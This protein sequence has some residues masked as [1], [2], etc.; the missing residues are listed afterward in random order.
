MA[1]CCA[2]SPNESEIVEST[3]VVP[4][5]GNMTSRP[6][7]TEDIGLTVAEPPKPAVTSPE[8][9]APEPASP[10]GSQYKESRTK[11]ET[12]LDDKKSVDIEALKVPG[13]S[14]PY[15]FIDNLYLIDKADPSNADG[16]IDKDEMLEILHDAADLKMAKLNN[17]AEMDYTKLPKAVSEV[18][19]TWD[20]DG[21]GKIGVAELQAAARAQQQ[22]A[23]AN[24]FLKGAIVVL[25]LI[26]LLLVSMMFISAE[27]MKDTKPNAAGIATVR[28]GSGA[29][30]AVASVEEQVKLK[31]LWKPEYTVA[32]LK[33]MKTVAF[34]TPTGQH[35][36]NVVGV[37]RR[38][39]GDADSKLT[40][41]TSSGHQLKITESA[42][43]LLY[44]EALTGESEG[45]VER[46][47]TKGMTKVNGRFVEPIFMNHKNGRRLQDGMEPGCSLGVEAVMGSYYYPEMPP[48]ETG[49]TT[50]EEGSELCEENGYTYCSFPGWPCPVPPCDYDTEMECWSNPP[51]A[52]WYDGI[53]PVT[54][55]T[56][57]CEST[58]SC[59]PAETGCPVTCGEFECMCTE[60]YME[61]SQVYAYNYCMYDWE[62]MGMCE[63]VCPAVVQAP[64]LY[65]NEY[66][67][68]TCIDETTGEEYCMPEKDGCKPDSV[69]P[70]VDAG[71]YDYMGTFHDHFDAGWGDC[72]TYDPTT[73]YNFYWC[74][75]DV[76]YFEDCGWDCWS[77][78]YQGV[79]AMEACDGCGMCVVE[80]D[81]SMMFEAAQ[82]EAFEEFPTT[83]PTPFPTSF[84]TPFPTPS[85]PS[86]T[87]FP[88]ALPTAFP[89]ALPTPSPT[90]SPEEVWCGY[91]EKQCGTG[92]AYGYGT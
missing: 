68:V 71:G 74:E 41:F 56:L 72:S 82:A 86:P 53:D 92:H 89:T 60:T 78:N 2:A 50:C 64:V 37:S 29:P 66:T 85:T 31:E 47:L 58:M 88:T 16:T 27:A 87:S 18:L 73:G 67:E 46:R 33:S 11:E 21:S 81:K 49:P 59:S 55:E 57:N 91:C 17:S 7:E 84:P 44:P 42:A 34:E 54:N 26:V 51:E 35:N 70:C 83:S 90:L 63:Y 6:I 39:V 61:G 45:I 75:Y 36:Y 80:S 12:M 22:M 65:C 1:S 24:K 20:T 69:N 3:G 79:S 8:P 5:G 38:T 48:E 62:G 23:Q 25:L 76:M 40:I 28:G 14:L 4:A 19:A 30:M 13:A 32:R 43:L 15:W 52:C 77:G 9:P 10:A